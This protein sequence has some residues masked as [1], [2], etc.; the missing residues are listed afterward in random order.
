M[1]RN[2]FAATIVAALALGA[3][4]L[5]ACQPNAVPGRGCAPEGD[6]GIGSVADGVNTYR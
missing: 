2:A 4:V 1:L 3:G 6:F 5:S